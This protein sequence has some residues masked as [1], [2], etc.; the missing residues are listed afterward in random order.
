M[1]RMEIRCRFVVSL[2]LILLL[3]MPVVSPVTT[4]QDVNYETT[5]TRSIRA[6]D[7]HGPIAIDSD[8]NFSATAL[9]EGWSGDGSAQDPYIIENYDIAMG[10]APEA[11]ISI[12]NTRVNYTIQGCNLIGPAATPSYGIN[13]ENSSN[14]RIINNLITNFAN[15]LNVSGACKNLVVA[16]NNI[17]YNS[18]S[19]WWGNSDNFTITNNYC[20]YNFFTGIYISDSDY[21]TISGNNCSG[22]GIFGIQLTYFSGYH[23]VTDN[24]CNRNANSGFRLQSAIENILENN[25]SNENEFGIWTT[26][27]NDNFIQWN[28]FANNTLDNGISDG[29]PSIWDYNYWSDYTGSDGNGDGIGDTSHTFS[30]VDYHPLMY[31]PF[32]VEWVIRPTD[33]HVEFGPDFEYSIPV[34]CPAPYDLRLNESTL[35]WVIMYTIGSSNRLD[36]GDYPLEVNVTNIYGYYTEAIFTVF[37]R[38]TTPP[39]TTHPDDLSYRV[40]DETN[41]LLEWTLSDLSTLT[42]VLLR[43]GSEVTS[44]DIP[45]SPIFFSTNIEDLP[46]G[47]YNYTIVAEDIWGNIATDMVLVTIQP[48]PFLEVLIPWLIISAVAIG[49]VLVTAILLRKRRSPKTE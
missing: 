49:V 39:T 27:S 22:N 32:P 8:A 1:L 38:D 41:Y 25:T 12:T 9:A 48:I 11:S 40:D 16:R 46:P 33:Q 26:A 29:T 15:G 13:L 20:S 47:V 36:V 43:N 34:I 3:L 18:Y 31:P 4:D 7:S 37:V 21:G 45:T 2:F 10:P 23:I 35:F 19:I 44:Y 30:D 28:I 5:S 24:I 17:S 14:G 42:F 6:N